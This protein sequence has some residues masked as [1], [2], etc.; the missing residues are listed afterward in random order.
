MKKI[1]QIYKEELACDRCGKVVDTTDKIT[2]YK[3][4]FDLDVW[5]YIWDG[6]TYNYN[7]GVGAD[8]RQF[9]WKRLKKQIKLEL[10]ESCWS[11]FRLFWQETDLGEQ[12]RA[13]HNQ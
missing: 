13:S 11:N 2:S 7:K 6:K 3:I 12:I 5:E 10:C 4:A 9:D 1:T 8:K